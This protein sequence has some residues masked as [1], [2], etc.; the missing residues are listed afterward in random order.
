VPAPAIWPLRLSPA[1]FARVH[2]ET[3]KPACAEL[4]RFNPTQQ[5]KGAATVRLR[6][7]FETKQQAFQSTQRFLG[8]ATSHS[9]RY[10][11]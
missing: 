5:P 3:L 2:A 4:E 7:V 11:K 1:S 8:A 10:R 6:Q 9:W